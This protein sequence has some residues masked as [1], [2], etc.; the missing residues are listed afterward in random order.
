MDEV[1]SLAKKEF[2]YLSVTAV[3]HVKILAG[4]SATFVT[5]PMMEWAILLRE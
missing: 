1:C 3:A 5:M 4:G 2:E